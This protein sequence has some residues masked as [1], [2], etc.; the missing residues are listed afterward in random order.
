MLGTQASLAAQIGDLIN[1]SAFA[2]SEGKKIGKME[3]SGGLLSFQDAL[4]LNITGYIL[5]GENFPTSGSGGPFSWQEEHFL[6]EAI[7]DAIFENPSVARLMFSSWSN[8]RT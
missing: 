6:K 7:V 8:T 2:G 5:A 1:K 4:L 3:P